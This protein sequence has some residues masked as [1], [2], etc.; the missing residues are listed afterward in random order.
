M[1]QLAKRTKLNND[2]NHLPLMKSSSEVSR[3]R[4]LWIN[5]CLR[6]VSVSGR[7]EGFLRKINVMKL[8]SSGDPFY[9]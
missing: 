4:Y 6:M 9:I 8:L 5:G 3:S 2:E 7:F 1:A